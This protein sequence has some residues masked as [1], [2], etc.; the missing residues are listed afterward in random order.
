MTVPWD[1]SILNEKAEE[2]VFIGLFSCVSF[3]FVFIFRGFYLFL[4]RNNLKHP[5]QFSDGF[6]F[7]F[8]QAEE[9]QKNTKFNET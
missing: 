8:A 9:M 6:D 4:Q 3:V 5:K 7:F 2:I 1:L